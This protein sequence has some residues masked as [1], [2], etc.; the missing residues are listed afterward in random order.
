MA[1][2]LPSLPAIQARAQLT[3]S[4]T[5]GCPAAEAGAP[6]PKPVDSARSASD[7]TRPSAGTRGPADV[8]FLLGFSADELRF[9]SQ[10]DARIRF[11]WG[12]DTL[13]IIERRNLP[14]PVLA[15]T[16]YRNVYIAAELRAYLNAECLA[17]RLGVADSTVRATPDSGCSG[18]SIKLGDGALAKPPPVQTTSV[19]RR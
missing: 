12:S 8:I 11:C 1:A 7:T 10:P 16:T 4:P 17:Q 3:I 19:S 18:I 15:G 13:H 9:N 2:L 14:S 6:L 5:G